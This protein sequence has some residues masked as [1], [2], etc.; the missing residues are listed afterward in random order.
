MKIRSITFF[1]NPK[2]PLDKELIRQA[3]EFATQARQA[4]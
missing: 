3:A 1:A 4:F 2:W